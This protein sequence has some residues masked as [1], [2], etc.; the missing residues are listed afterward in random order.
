M[1]NLSFLK[2]ALIVASPVV[3]GACAL[4]APTTIGA[5]TPTTTTPGSTTTTTIA[6]SAMLHPGQSMVLGQDLLNPAG[7]AYAQF[8]MKGDFILHSGNLVTWHSKTTNKGGTTITMQ[9]DGNLVMRTATGKVLWASHT[10]ASGNWLELDPLGNLDIFSSGDVLLWTN[11]KLTTNTASDLGPGQELITGQYLVSLDGSQQVALSS[12]GA[13]FEAPLVNPGS[14]GWTSPVAGGTNLY[15]NPNGDLELRDTSNH[16]LWSTLTA[17]HPGTQLQVL[18]SG[19]VQLITP[20]NLAIWHVS[21][22]TPPV[23][24]TALG[25]KVVSI[26][27]SY[28]QFS[29]HPVVETPMGSECNP[30]A[31]YLGWG[32]PTYTVGSKS[33]SCP[34]GTRS[35]SWCADFGTWLWKTAGAV[36]TGLTAWSYSFVQYGLAHNTFKLGALNHPQIG[37]A[38]VFGTYNTK[39]PYSGYGAHVGFVAAVKGNR[40]QMVSGNWNEAVVLTGFFDPT[41]SGNGSGYPIIGYI[42]P[43]KSSSTTTTTTTTTT[44]PVTTTTLHPAPTGATSR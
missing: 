12:L 7:V 26:A 38:I 18:N 28:D 2:R 11:G 3:I 23:I 35:Q 20:N 9:L 42:S 10:S 43:V 21:P 24:S 44:T 19:V 5:T 33:V 41:T 17:H 4:I 22:T 14:V 13:V 31:K 39:D 32:T 25:A 37:D 34:A 40:I 16:V 36:S 8:T 6:A 29:K 27:E 30:F 1:L 15:M